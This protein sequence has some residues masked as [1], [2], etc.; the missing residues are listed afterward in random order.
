MRRGE[1]GGLFSQ[2]T[3]VNNL[4]YGKLALQN[5]LQNLSRSEIFSFCQAF[6]RMMKIV[7]LLFFFSCAV[8]DLTQA[9]TFIGK[10][11]IYVN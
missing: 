2:A 5:S 8:L 1:E 7:V 9:Q 10:Y 6:G 4:T 3:F 11:N